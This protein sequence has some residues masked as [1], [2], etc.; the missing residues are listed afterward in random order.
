MRG[1]M[2]DVSQG[3]GWWIASDGRWYAPEQHPNYRPPPPPTG[4][5]LGLAEQQA[6]APSTMQEP[7]IHKVST[8]PS[9]VETAPQAEQTFCIL[10]GFSL[11]SQ[12]AFCPQCG[13]RS[14]PAELAEQRS[15]PGLQKKSADGATC[16]TCGEK[17]V[18]VPGGSYSTT[19]IWVH[20]STGRRTC[21]P[22][23]PAHGATVSAHTSGMAVASLVL[24]LLWLGGIGALLA[25]IF[26]VS[27]RNEI[28]RSNGSVTGRGMALWG[29]ALGWIG[30]I[31][32]IF[33][34]VVLVV[35]VHSANNQSLGLHIS[36]SG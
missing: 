27:G 14:T 34:I 30:L 23:A 1:G 28:D 16:R 7:P 12:A 32:A 33:W 6:S 29:I 21:D 31:G 10:C 11:P 26:G 22:R 35:A 25:I 20:A 2:S 3:P 5:P 19:P 15:E 18:K 36:P 8:A 9:S 24:G 4:N 17:V 13:G